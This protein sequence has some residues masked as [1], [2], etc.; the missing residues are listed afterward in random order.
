MNIY[1]SK[2]IFIQIPEQMNIYEGKWNYQLASRYD[3]NGFGS[4]KAEKVGGGYGQG[5]HEQCKLRELLKEIRLINYVKY[6][7]VEGQDL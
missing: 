1:L 4:N 7:C 2:W 6:Y 5:L 3:L